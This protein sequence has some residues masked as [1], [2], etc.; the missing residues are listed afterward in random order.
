MILHTCIVHICICNGNT[1][2]AHFQW[3]KIMHIILLHNHNTTSN[4][5]KSYM[6]RIFRRFMHAYH[7]NGIWKPHHTNE[8]TIKDDINRTTMAMTR[9]LYG[10]WQTVYMYIYALYFCSHIHFVCN[11]A[12][13]CCRLRVCSSR[14]V[15]IHTQLQLKGKIFLRTCTGEY[16]TDDEL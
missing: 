15:Y 13:R 1:Y 3:K 4:S 5:R 9:R 6:W 2:L 16:T 12:Y 7:A 14:L 8:I 11:K 10:V